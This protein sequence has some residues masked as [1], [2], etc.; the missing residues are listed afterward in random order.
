MSRIAPAVEV[1]GL[2]DLVAALRDAARLPGLLVYVA[3]ELGDNATAEARPCGSAPVVGVG[4]DLLDDHR[5]PE[6][7]GSVAH[8]IAHHALGHLSGW[9]VPALDWLYIW[10]CVA[11]IMSA[12]LPVPGW[13]SPALL[14]L[15]LA[16]RLCVSWLRRAAE[17]AAD[18]HAVALLDSL[19]M[20]GRQIV[21]AMLTR[22]LAV[23]PI[24][25]AMV[26]WLAGTHPPAHARLRRLADAPSFTLHG[27]EV[28]S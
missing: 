23:E 1:A 12:F 11:G 14:S 18:R 27:L 9:L 2:A 6:L 22:D 26:G 28:T 5:S 24:W 16:A 3:G 10:T 25:Y 7:V 20:P 17:F 15:A 13:I 8:E 4:A 21:T 19:G